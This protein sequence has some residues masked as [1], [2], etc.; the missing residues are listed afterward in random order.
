MREKPLPEAIRGSWYY[1]SSDLEMPAGLAKGANVLCFRGDSSFARYQFR[2][3][4]M[5]E[6]ERGTYTFDG[7]FLILRGR[8]T[9]TFRVRVAGPWKWTMEGKRVDQ[10]L[11]RGLFESEEPVELSAEEAREIRILPVRVSVKVPWS[12]AEAVHDLVYQSGEGPVRRI[13]SFYVERGSEGRLS[14]GLTM[15]VTGLESRTWERIIRECYLDLFLGKP[16]DVGVVTVRLLQTGESRV[17]NYH[18]GGTG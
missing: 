7:N 16:L 14:V 5:R 8:V 18:A 1:I 11:L 17:F 6:A 9:D 15:A 12:G 13:G 2:E 3:T 10:W 4:E